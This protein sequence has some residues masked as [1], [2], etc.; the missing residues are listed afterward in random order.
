MSLEKHREEKENLR[1]ELIDLFTKRHEASLRIE[2]VQKELQLIDEKL[3]AAEAVREATAKIELITQ[4]TR[5]KLKEAGEREEAAQ[6]LVEEFQFKLAEESQAKKEVKQLAEDYQARLEE[7]TQA[8]IEAQEAIQQR[9]EEYQATLKEVQERESEE[10]Q[11]LSAKV[12]EIETLKKRLDQTKFGLQKVEVE[13]DI[14]EQAEKPV[15]LATDSDAPIT[16]AKPIDETLLIQDK[17]K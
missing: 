3:E 4:E 2:Y 17:K 6:K 14:L 12:T 5:S 15:D 13:K 1:D 9:E 8:K 10:S 16:P 7:E 11:E